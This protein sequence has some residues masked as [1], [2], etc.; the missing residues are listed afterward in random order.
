[1]SRLLTTTL[2]ASLFSVGATAQTEPFSTVPANHWFY[3]ALVL[4][5]CE[6]VPGELTRY[7]VALRV[8]KRINALGA[9]DSSGPLD[10]Q[11][12]ALFKL[13]S[14]LRSELAQLGI[15]LE[16]IAK[17][18]PSSPP[19]PRPAVTIPARDFAVAPHAL[20][21]LRSS[22]AAA[23]VGGFVVGFQ[24]DDGG[25]P[26]LRLGLAP[27]RSSAWGP[28]SHSAGRLPGESLGD[29]PTLGGRMLGYQPSG[30]ALSGQLGSADISASVALP[31][32]NGF[33][34]PGTPTDTLRPDYSIGAQVPLGF[35]AGS[36]STSYAR[37][38]D[39]AGTS[40]DS[41]V[42]THL[43]LQLS[44]GLSVSASL[45][46]AG[47]NPFKGETSWKAEASY[48]P[49]SLTAGAGIMGVDPDFVR[50]GYFGPALFDTHQPLRGVG[51]SVTYRG[52]DSLTLRGGVEG[53]GLESESDL[54]FR[55]YLA[56]VGYT[57]NERLE[58]DLSLARLETL[59]ERDQTSTYATLGL[60]FNFSS[61]VSVKLLY[62][63]LDL[64]DSADSG[65]TAASNVM[66]TQFSV[67]F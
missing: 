4:A 56:G 28:S 22:F 41:I 38:T 29:G 10:P 7:D 25:L 2:I 65:K 47:I 30:L 64:Q 18:R 9:A 17:L 14:A 54:S 5:G 40:R 63:V 52:G 59:G 62:R 21:S 60:G 33:T 46:R 3:S 12:E 57:L 32:L 35:T 37:V 67:R 50:L 13:A 61:D 11:R 20:P 31:D 58:L 15:D 49:G 44:R 27:E 24:A 43:D 26:A 39:L 36:V 6:P 19:T 45:A 34:A 1:M 8:A 42:T 51:G 53:Y 48:S 55:R 66:A 16:S 23:P